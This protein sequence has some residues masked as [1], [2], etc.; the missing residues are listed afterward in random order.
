MRILIY[1]FLLLNLLFGNSSFAQNFRSTTFDQRTICEKDQGVWREFG[2][3]CVDSCRSKFNKFTMCTSAL[4]YGCDCGTN[5]CWYDGKCVANDEYQKTYDLEKSKENVRLE[6]LKQQRRQKYD[7]NR[8]M[9]VKRLNNVSDLEDR[10]F[11]VKNKV[12][13]VTK[14]RPK[15][16]NNNFGHSPLV[17]LIVEQG[18]QVIKGS[19]SKDPKQKF[20]IPDYFA[21][22]QEEQKNK[23]IDQENKQNDT[24][25]ANNDPNGNATLPDQNNQVDQLP[26]LPM[27]VLPK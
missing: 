8:R 12:N 14:T 9:I 27:V 17:D 16:G 6:K 24:N 13:K 15:A 19:N 7:H 23:Q 10:V 22:K 2:N 26:E 5:R 21:R 18:K 25:K 4:T 3:G 11:E 20:K 1:V